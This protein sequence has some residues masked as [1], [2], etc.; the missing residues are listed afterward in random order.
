MIGLTSKKSNRA[1]Q[2]F[3]LLWNFRVVLLS[4]YVWLRLVGR[5]FR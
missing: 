2:D 4:A 5:V 1:L 3:L